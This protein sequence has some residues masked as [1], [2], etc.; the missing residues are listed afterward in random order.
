MRA[1]W[2]PSGSRSWRAC[3]RLL[4]VVGGGIVAEMLKALAGLLDHGFSDG[5]FVAVLI[6][7]SGAVEGAFGVLAVQVH[8]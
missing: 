7:D 2:P 6:N 1:G 8:G 3:L 4:E 5:H